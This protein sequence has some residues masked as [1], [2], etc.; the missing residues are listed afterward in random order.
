MWIWCWA[1]MT[2][3]RRYKSALPVYPH[4][5]YFVRVT[6]N[7]TV[8]TRIY[9]SSALSERPKT[10]LYLWRHAYLQRLPKLLGLACLA[11]PTETQRFFSC[12]WLA[13]RG[14]THRIIW[15]RGSIKTV[16]A[17]L[18]MRQHS[19]R[20]WAKS[21]LK[22]RLVSANRMEVSWSLVLSQLSRLI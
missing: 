14:F 6:S 3:K 22:L 9:I 19:V 4:L 20:L 11:T 5:A 8:W 7:S 13:A 2:T 18:V 15:L 21:K 17:T 16:F 10:K 1:Y 12:Q